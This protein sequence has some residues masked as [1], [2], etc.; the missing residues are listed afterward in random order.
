MVD[1][2]ANAVRAARPMRSTRSGLHGVCSHRSAARYPRSSGEREALRAL[3][4]AR[5]G[6]AIAKT[7][8]LN[9]LHAL[10]VTTP[11]PLRGEL[12]P[13]TR[14]RLLSRLAAT[15]PEQRRDPEL[16]GTLLALRTVAR[17]V[18]QLTHRRARARTRDREARSQSRPSAA[19]PARRRCA[20]AAQVAALLVPPR[21]PSERGR[22]RPAR[23]HRP[24][25]SLLRPDDPLPPR[26]RR[27]P[28]TQPD[29]APD[30]HHPETHARAR[31]STT[32][33]AAQAKARPAAKQPA[34]SS[35]TSPATSTAYS[36][37]RHATLD[38]HRSIA[39]AAD[40]GPLFSI[41]VP[42]SNST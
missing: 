21:P 32:S 37:T 36:K 34:A 40:S 11:E 6:A 39:R 18:L 19:R 17:R 16:R 23:R 14:A 5:E 33:H 4:A 24:D 42:P 30:P 20:L 31:R 13:L 28:K 25:P 22:V 1:F 38:K 8:G 35:A 15:R 3:M 29:A 27:R 9:Q 2:V 10:L 7:A 41:P 12:R 26:P